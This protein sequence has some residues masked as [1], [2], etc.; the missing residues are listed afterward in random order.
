MKTILNPLEKG[1][2]LSD[3]TYEGCRYDKI[4]PGQVF[5]VLSEGLAEFLLTTFPVLEL[6][7]NAPVAANDYCCSKCG[8]DCGSKYMK[9]RH[10][11]VC[12]AE[13]KKMAVILR[14]SYIFWNYKNLDKTQ[15]TEDQL[16]PSD[17]IANQPKIDVTVVHDTIMTE[18][19]LA[20]PAAGIT[21]SGKVAGRDRI[22][23]TDREG[24]DWYGEGVEDDN[25]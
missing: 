10:E 17:Q 8:K 20:I 18:E 7:K 12:K 16:L 22:I 13:N 24:V 6:V 9:E 3:F 11:K 2:T 4:E 1:M 14:P 25:A 5:S 23:T 21:R 19:S 15:L